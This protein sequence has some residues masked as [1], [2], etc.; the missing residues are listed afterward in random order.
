MNFAMLYC[1]LAIG[2]IKSCKGKVTR[3]TGVQVDGD[4]MSTAFCSRHLLA[5]VTLSPWTFDASVDEPQGCVNEL[6]HADCARCR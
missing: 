1:Q 3:H 4:K 6:P 2:I 5:T